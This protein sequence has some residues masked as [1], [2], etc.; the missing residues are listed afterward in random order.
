[1]VL[2]DLLRRGRAEEAPVSALGSEGRTQGKGTELGQGRVRLGTGSP[3]CALRVLWHCN[4]LARE[5]VGARARQ[6]SRGVWI[7]P[8]VIRFNF[9]LALKQSGSWP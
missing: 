5:L 2:C 9:R 7:M 3:V 1:M 4:G 6:C 8:S